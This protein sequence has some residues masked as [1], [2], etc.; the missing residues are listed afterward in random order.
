MISV[1][2]EVAQFASWP[3]RER[4]RALKRIIPR[5]NVEDVLEKSGR[6][7]GFCRRLP[8]WFM[9]WFVIAL[10]LFC[11]D[12]YRQVFRWLQPYR[13]GGTPGRSTLCEARKRLGLAPFRALAKT[14]VRLLGKPDAPGAFYRGMRLM[15]L[16][17]FVL[18]LPDTPENERVF[19]RPGSG[20]APG[21]FPQARVL[22]LCETGSHVLW[23]WL[24]KSIRI[25]EVTMAHHLLGCLEKGMLL[26]WDRGFF[27]YQTIR[28]VLDRRAE[29]LARVKNGLIFQPFRRLSDGSYLAKVYRTPRD[30]RKDQNGI[31][32]RIIEYTF[33]DPG[34]PGC[35]IMH[36]LL[37]TLLDETLDAART[38]IELYHERWEEELAIDEVKTHQRERPILRSRTPLGVLQEIYGL[39]LGHYAV[40]VLMYEAAVAKGIDPQRI[41]FTAT[42]KI[43]RCR[44]P[45]CPSSLRCLRT[46][47]KALLE[48]IGEEILPDRRNRINPRVIKRKMSRWEKKK[49]KHCRYPQPAKE[50]RPAIVLL[51]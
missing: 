8:G 31:I 36:R 1:D 47:H 7:R 15:A 24:I 51:N 29:L 32:V 11:R 26:L 23:R 14:V 28:E 45:E 2:K 3:T 30:R 17:G 20:R 42:L 16:D 43:L 48:E 50:F 39:L 49:P 35:G 33:D 6:A 9:V 4:I 18:D 40:R 38:L 37:T 46:W 10:G 22:A 13:R 25:G 19:G 27:S 21:A 12:S 34:R 44:L 41:S 5:A